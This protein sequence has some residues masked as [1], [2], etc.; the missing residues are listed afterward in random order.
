MM[1]KKVIFVNDFWNYQGG[2]ELTFEALIEKCPYQHEKKESQAITKEYLQQNKK[3]LFILGNL[4]LLSDELKFYFCK[5]INYCLLEFDYRICKHR[6]PQLH[7]DSN[8]DC[9]KTLLAN[10]KTNMLL[11]FHSKINFFMSEQ[12]KNYYLKNVSKLKNK[13]NIVI[14]SAFCDKDMSTIKSQKIDN[15]NDTWLIQKSNSWVKGTKNSIKYAT[16]KKLNF[17]LFENLTREQMLSLFA[18]SK[19]FIFLPNGFDTCPRTIIEAK[20]LGCEI[21][22]NDYVQH[23]QEKWFLNKTSIW[24]KIQNN[25]VEF[26]NI[27]K[28]HE[29]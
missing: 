26:W 17:K 18:S 22:C 6:L 13:N 2:A 14:S 8:C 27:I 10:I 25:K 28:D 4:S 9:Q 24:D 12:Q 23:S 29:K 11:L 15:K 19:G 7:V 5:N 20:L 16:E 21:I 1:S 3:N